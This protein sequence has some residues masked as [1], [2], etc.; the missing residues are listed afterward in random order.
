MNEKNQ[1]EGT[2]SIVSYLREKQA[3]LD[4]VEKLWWVQNDIVEKQPKKDV[5]TF[6]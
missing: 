1:I 6:A 4:V 2:I 3:K 5:R